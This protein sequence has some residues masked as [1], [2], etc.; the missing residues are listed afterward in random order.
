MRTV[1]ITQHFGHLEEKLE[2]R[3]AKARAPRSAHEIVG[4]CFAN[5]L[6]E[7]EEKLRSEH[8]RA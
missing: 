8:H 4:D 5:G 6:P 3:V 2:L 1:S 7:R